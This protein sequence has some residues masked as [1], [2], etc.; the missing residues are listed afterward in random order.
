MVPKFS[1]LQGRAL[2]VLARYEQLTEL[3]VESSVIEDF[4]FRDIRFLQP[5]MH[6]HLNGSSGFTPNGLLY[7]D[8]LPELQTL[9]MSHCQLTDEHLRPIGKLR[10]VRVLDL[11]S[12]PITDKGIRHLNDMQYLEVLYLNETKTTAFGL[13]E[14]KSLRSI[15]AIHVDH[16]EPRYLHDRLRHKVSYRKNYG[17]P[18]LRTGAD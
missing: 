17:Q 9:S 12:T 10:F 3:H 4:I 15:R 18:A 5:L 8:S 16:V 7:L 2:S 13:N 1:E 14:L 6:L 11:R